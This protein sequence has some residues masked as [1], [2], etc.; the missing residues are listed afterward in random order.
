[1]SP[2]TI[3]VLTLRAHVFVF[4]GAGASTWI[5]QNPDFPLNDPSD[6]L[7]YS[8]HCYLDRDNSGTH[9]NWQ[10]E[11]AHGVTVHTGEERLAPF[12]NWTRQ[13]KVRAHLGEMGIG[14]DDDG[15]A[16]QHTTHNSI[17]TEPGAA[18]WS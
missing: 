4:Q 14:S 8:C 9:F 18:A 13:H 1:M 6:N 2:V 15:G 5:E 7:V 11:V 3:P 16:A 17:A 10:E 12:V